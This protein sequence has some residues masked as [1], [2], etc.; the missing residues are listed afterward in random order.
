MATVT[1]LKA[2]V[3]N[4]NLPILGDDGNLYNYYVG[5]WLN[6]IRNLGYA[7]SAGEISAL[8]TLIVSGINDGWI[9]KVLYFIPLIGSQ[10]NPLT[11]LVPLI[12][13]VADYE[14]AETSVDSDAFSYL[15]G[16]IIGYGN[17]SLSTPIRL[18]IPVT[19]GDIAD[20]GFSTYANVKVTAEE[21]ASPF[22]RPLLSAYPSGEGASLIWTV[23]LDASNRYQMSVRATEEGELTI[24]TLDAVPSSGQFGLFFAR[25]YD[26]V[27]QV[28]RAKKY[29]IKKGAS[30]PYANDMA[31]ITTESIVNTTPYRYCLG[32]YQ[33]TKAIVNMCAI[34]EPNSLTASDMLA[35]NQAVFAL[36]TALGR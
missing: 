28:N 27:G 12:D 21:Y 10:S 33:V 16:K 20:I 30:S 2:A 29:F 1:K 8:N 17:P 32:G 13:N 35:F 26:S 6:K 31:G 25:Y 9:N 18:N 14:L 11:G 3:N 24:A 36:T 4:K 15:D 7:P 34:I 23:R 5:T 19:T 22:I